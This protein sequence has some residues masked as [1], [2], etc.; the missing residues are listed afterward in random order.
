MNRHHSHCFGYRQDCTHVPPNWVTFL[1]HCESDARTPTSTAAPQTSAPTDTRDLNQARAEAEIESLLPPGSQGAIVR[2]DLGGRTVIEAAVGGVAVDSGRP[3]T[4]GHPFRL[5]DTTTPI[6]AATILR[7]HEQGHLSIDDTIAEYLPMDLVAELHIVDG[8]ARGN[9]ITIRHLLAHTAGLAD[10]TLDSP[11]FDEVMADPS[12]VWRTRDLVEYSTAHAE[13]VFAPGTS[14][15]Y[16]D[17][18]YVLL[19]MIIEAATGQPRH[20]VYR[21]QVLDPL[22]MDATYLEGH[23]PARGLELS[24]PYLG[25]FDAIAVH[26]SVE[27]GG[28]GLVS[29]VADL[30]RFGTALVNGALFEQSETLK[31]MRHD[32][33]TG[34]GLGL[35]TS[36]TRNGLTILGHDGY[37]GTVLL[38]VPELDLVL[39]ATINKFV[40][41]KTKEAFFSAL[42]DLIPTGQP[43]FAPHRHRAPGSDHPP[44][45]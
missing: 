17:D 39:A 7:L 24:H 9:D 31:E 32:K 34:Y 41:S 18:G 25:D 29:T 40:D 27:W 11:I 15:S 21:K 30:A 14:F 22:A 8:V 20:E 42:I 1:S 45:I 19:G 5:A 28:G 38:V 35:Y 13:P 4:T 23:E 33:G 3:L 2:A 6:T 37:W 10:R 12:R 43:R 36:S 26:P 16:S 44:L